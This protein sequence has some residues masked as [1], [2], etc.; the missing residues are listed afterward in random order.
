MGEAKRRRMLRAIQHAHHQGQGVWELTVLFADQ[1]IPMIMASASG[2]A[3]ATRRCQAVANT[4][5]QI[6]AHASPRNAPLCLLC[7]TSLWHDHPPGAVVIVHAYHHAPDSIMASAICPAC[8]AKPG[9][10][11]REAILNAYR[12]QFFRDDS[13][14]AMPMPSAPGHA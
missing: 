9:T 6:G 4:I 3:E 14:R 10:E 8:S 12:Q 1:L 7:E 13:V 5:G 11:L 2:N